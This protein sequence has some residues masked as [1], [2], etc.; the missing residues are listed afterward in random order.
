[1]LPRSSSSRDW[2]PIPSGWQTGSA[3]VWWDRNLRSP[4]GLFAGGLA[5]RVGPV[6]VSE[7]KLQPKIKCK[8][9]LCFCYETP[10]EFP[11]MPLYPSHRKKTPRLPHRVLCVETLLWVF[12]LSSSP[13][14]QLP[15]TTHDSLSISQTERSPPSCLHRVCHTLGMIA[16]SKR[17]SFPKRALD[18]A[19]GSG[20]SRTFSLSRR[21]RGLRRKLPWVCKAQEDR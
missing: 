10:R 1:M 13:R 18:I 14:G 20:A 19:D 16:P 6:T 9:L 8:S 21:K 4:V 12:V 7:S 3:D 2:L 11:I 17:T 5:A 15:S